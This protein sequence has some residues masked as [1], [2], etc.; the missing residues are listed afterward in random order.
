MCMTHLQNSKNNFKFL[1]FIFKQKPKYNRPLNI[2]WII[3]N[4]FNQL[5]WSIAIVVLTI[6]LHTAAVSI[7]FGYEWGRE[8]VSATNFETEM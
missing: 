1:C 4:E 5:S 3:K 2:G 6:N 8:Q 7:V